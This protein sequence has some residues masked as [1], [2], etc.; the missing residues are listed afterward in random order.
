MNLPNP[1]HSW[2]Q[3]ELFR[4]QYGVLPAGDDMRPLDVPIALRNMAKAI[5]DGCS[6]GD[7]ENMPSPSNVVSVLEYAAYLLESKP[8]S[9]KPPK[10][11]GWK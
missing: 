11:K 10:P 1:S 4:W 5:I 7:R 3:V 2:A 6:T 8:K 9:V